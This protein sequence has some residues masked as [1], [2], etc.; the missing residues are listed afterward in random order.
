[1]SEKYS[2]EH[3]DANLS[4]K[5]NDNLWLILA[6]L[7]RPY[8][9]TVIS[10]VNRTDR[11]AIINLVYSD[12]MALW[13]GL[14]AGVPAALVFYAWGRRKP[15]ASAFVRK[16]W[17]R[18]RELL[19]VSALA[20]AAVVFVPHWIGAVYHVSTAG[21]IQLGISIGIVIVL[22]SSTYI[23]DCFADFPAAVETGKNSQSAASGQRKAK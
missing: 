20:N 2:I 7:L 9:V 17:A 1:M 6:F 10:L 21:W 14:L 12:K 16:V 15:G 22:Y 3:Y 11:T 23:R 13:W 5:M 19:A 8:F 4:L 18:G